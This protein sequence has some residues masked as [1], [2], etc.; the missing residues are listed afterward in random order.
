LLLS[1]HLSSELDEVSG[2]KTQIMY[3]E[4]TVVHFAFV[5]FAVFGYVIVIN[6]YLWLLRASLR[7]PTKRMHLSDALSLNEQISTLVDR[8]IRKRPKKLDAFIS[9]FS[10]NY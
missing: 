9:F 1:D 10:R 3:L 5:M 2:K 8:A 7:I 6:P 4:N